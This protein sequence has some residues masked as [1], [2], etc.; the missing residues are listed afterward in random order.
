MNLSRQLGLME[1]GVR[2]YTDLVR[3]EAG[4]SKIGGGDGILSVVVT[5]NLPLRFP[6]CYV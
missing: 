1:A 6:T 3:P 5:T 4:P 2:Q